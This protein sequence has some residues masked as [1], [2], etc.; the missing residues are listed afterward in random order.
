[1]P[2]ECHCMD[3]L[4]LFQ[5]PWLI[6]QSSVW[7]HHKHTH[8]PWLA[9]MAITVQHVRAAVGHNQGASVF[10]D[11]VLCNIA[12]S[13]RALLKMQIWHCT[14]ACLHYCSI[15]GLILF[16]T[17][18]YV[19]RV[20]CKIQWWTYRS[21]HA[22]I[23]LVTS[24]TVYSCPLTGFHKRNSITWLLHH[25]LAELFTGEKTRSKQQQTKVNS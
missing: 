14:G 10:R 2:A 17:V 25:R 5:W 16:N 4:V 12:L 19:W 24:C 22:A 7:L 21:K 23:R 3:P 1:M 13:W 9:C 6:M 18:V 20:G 15:V 8:T 11:V